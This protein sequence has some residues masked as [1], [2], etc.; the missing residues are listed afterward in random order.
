MVT[1]LLSQQCRKGTVCIAILPTQHT[2]NVTV[3]AAEQTKLEDLHKSITACDDILT[4]VEA[5]L[6]NFRDD[7]ANVSADIESLQDRSTALNQRLE[8]RRK[9][10][11]ALAP[12]VEDLSL[13]PE[14]ITKIAAGPIDESWIKIL[15]ELDRRA[16]SFKKRAAEP[17]QSKAASDL[18]PLLEKLTQ[19]AVERIRDF[20]VTQIKALRSPNV[21]AQ[22]IQ[23]QKFLRLKEL[24]HF[25]HRH[26]SVLAD[27][28]VQAYLNTMRWYYQSQFARYEKSLAKMKLH[29]LDKSDAIGYEE[30]SRMGSVLSVSRAAAPPH[31]AFNLGRR[32]EILKA[33][34]MPALSSHL[35]EEDKTVRYLESPFRNLNLA[36]IDNATAEYT[37]MASYFAPSLSFAKINQNFNFVFDPSFAIGQELSKT[38]VADTYD[39]IGVLLCIRLNQQQAF[40][41]QRRKVPT[42]DNYINVTNM[43]L[44]PRFQVIMDKH[45]ESVKQLSAAVPIKPNK[46]DTSKLSAA[47]HM[48]TQRFGQLLQAFLALSEDAG[49]DEPVVASLFRLRTEVEGFLT[50]IGNSYGTDRRKSSRF[51]YNNYSLIHTIISDATGKLAEDQQ[52]HFEELK[53]AY[54]EDD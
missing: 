47:P 38:L 13:S 23:Q 5:N 3:D 27:E 44:W 42:A 31:D 24:F 14:I 40:E 11:K 43:L 46:S 36:L 1:M 34:H 50:K 2:A 7:L 6:A 37:F 39:A 25:L 30:T 20:I 15:A 52:E 26:H 45:S 22:V 35:A 54:Q 53:R 16:T 4:S 29:I 41:L 49:D 12:M 28:I 19:K 32:M 9:V 33:S 17:T 8:N 21:N 51:M 18:A 48:V 10:E